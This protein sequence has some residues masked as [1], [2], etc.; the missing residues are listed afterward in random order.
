MSA[1]EPETRISDDSVSRYELATHCWPASPPPRSS[2][3]FGS[4]TLTTV[5]S[6][7][8]TAEPRIAATRAPRFA[9]MRRTL[10]GGPRRAREPLLDPRDEVVEHA[11]AIGLALVEDLVVEVVV[12]PRGRARRQRG[13]QLARPRRVDDPVVA[14]REQ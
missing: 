1:S 11:R 10:Q 2:A 9:S 13:R 3:I 8:T 12:D 7:A 14:R 6:T 4:A 5:A